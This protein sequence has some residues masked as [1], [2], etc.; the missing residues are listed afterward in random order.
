MPTR[1]SRRRF[2]ARGW[3]RKTEDSAGADE[4]RSWPSR[5]EISRAVSPPHARIE[6]ERW[7]QAGVEKA[8]QQRDRDME[9]AG[10]AKAPWPPLL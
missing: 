7:G 9:W 2:A 1:S 3:P 4:V 5:S 10:Q 6:T 8:P